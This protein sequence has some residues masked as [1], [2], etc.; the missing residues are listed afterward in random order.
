MLGML[1]SFGWYLLLGVT[2]AQVNYRDPTNLIWLIKLAV[3]K[4]NVQSFVY[5]QG[6]K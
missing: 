6:E 3:F 1:A 2:L 5:F 4:L